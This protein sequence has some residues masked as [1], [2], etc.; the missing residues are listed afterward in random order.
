MAILKRLT[1]AYGWFEEEGTRSIVSR[2]T[3][4]FTKVLFWFQ[5]KLDKKQSIDLINKCKKE[6][7]ATEGE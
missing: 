4:V 3:I 6:T 1:D 7:G 2:T 5:A